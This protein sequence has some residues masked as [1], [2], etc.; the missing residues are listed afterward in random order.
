VRKGIVELSSI[1]GETP[2]LKAMLDSLDTDGSG[3][4]DYNEFIACCM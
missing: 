1:K 3:A 2:E 4:I